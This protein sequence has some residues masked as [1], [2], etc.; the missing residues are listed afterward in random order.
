MKLSSILFI[1]LFLG[2]TAAPRAA[3]MYSTKLSFMGAGT[4]YGPGRLSDSVL[5]DAQINNIAF[6]S[7]L[8]F[9]TA[10][11]NNG[12]AQ[13]NI[14][15]ERET[16]Q[17]PTGLLSDN[18]TKI[19]ENVDVCSFQITGKQILVAV[20][21][22]GLHHGEQIAVALSGGQMLMTMDFAMDLGIGPSG[23]IRM[24]FNGTTGEVEIP[25][26]LQTQLHIPGGV[27]RAG[28]LKSGDKLRGRFGDFNHDGMLDGAI[29]VAGN[30]PLTSVFMPGAPYALIRYFETDIP[31]DGH[32]VG[33]LVGRHGEQ[34]EPP[35]LTVLPPESTPASGE[36]AGAHR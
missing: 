20:V 5:F 16:R 21:D 13:P 32:L 6:P 24:P 23:I 25:L 2:A 7:P 12:G 28:S 18:V 8:T 35:R 26:S 29:V 36:L 22:G 34:G 11:G 30:I 15:G 27:D 14:C 3:T 4:F 33:K 9:V 10:L 19:N 1:S 31:Y 17:T